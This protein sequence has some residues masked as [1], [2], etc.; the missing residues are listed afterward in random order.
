MI[1]TSPENKTKNKGF[2]LIELLVVVLIIGILA[3]VALPQ[4]EKEVNK[5]RPAEVYAAV[6][7]IRRNLEMCK[8]SATDCTP[9][10][11]MEGP[12]WEHQDSFNTNGAMKGKYFIEG[13]RIWGI[14]FFPIDGNN[15][16]GIILSSPADDTSG[17]ADTQLLCAGYMEKDISFCKSICGSAA[18][19]M[20]THQAI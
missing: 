13:M 16:Y 1:S 8:L 2:T 18:C 15:D 9:D 5:S 14:V 19:D 3:A 20:E 11:T 12:A 10:L 6:A 7:V 4:H 17:A